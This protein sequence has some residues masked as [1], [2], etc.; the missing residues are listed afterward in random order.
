MRTIEIK[1]YTIDEHP[2]KEKCFEWIRNNLHDLNQHSIDEIVESIRA[3]SEII[4]GTYDYSIS[5]V[6]DR[7]EHITCLLYTSPS[8]RDRG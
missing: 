4:G 7:G 1:V 3:L 8:P 5:Q 2:D 6:S